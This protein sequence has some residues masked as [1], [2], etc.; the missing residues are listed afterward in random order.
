MKI[1]SIT[2]VAYFF[3]IIIAIIIIYTIFRSLPRG[4][5]GS[6]ET[7]YCDHTG[8]HDKKYRSMRVQHSAYFVYALNDTTFSRALQYMKTRYFC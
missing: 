4:T 6:A 3:I 8:Y 1:G 2:H 5:C 7:Y